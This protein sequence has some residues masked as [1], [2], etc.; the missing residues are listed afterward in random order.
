MLL[1]RHVAF[2]ACQGHHEPALLVRCILDHFVD[3]VLHSIEGPFV[4]QVVADDGPNCVAV[5]QVDHRAEF[6]RTASVPDVQLHL[7][8]RPR[9][10]LLVG[11]VDRLL[12]VGTSDGDIVQLVKAVL[13]EAQR[14]RGLADATFAQQDDL[15]LD[16]AAFARASGLSGLGVDHLEGS[17]LGL[18]FLRLGATAAAAAFRLGFFHTS[19]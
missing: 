2:V 4:G 13:T 7:L 19:L 15:S 18:L 3:P 8:V 16:W 12:N 5:V 1:D 10:V 9:W 17:C 6:F 14:N 11:D